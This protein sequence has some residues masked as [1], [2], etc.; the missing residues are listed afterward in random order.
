MNR[1]IRRMS[2]LRTN[3]VKWGDKK[4]RTRTE[5]KPNDEHCKTIPNEVNGWLATM[6]FITA[7][8]LICLRH[9]LLV[10]ITCPEIE[11]SLSHAS[12]QLGDHGCSHRQFRDMDNDAIHPSKCT[13]S[14][15]KHL[16]I[17]ISSAIFVESV[18]LEFDMYM[19]FIIPF[20]IIEWA[21]ECESM[22]T[23]VIACL[24]MFKY[25]WF[26]FRFH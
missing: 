8:C 14:R 20:E 22:M 21:I 6:N 13:K 7:L 9:V 11:F 2:A 23:N 24:S 19:Q 12:D 1:W 5:D 25:A 18:P 17:F 15:V 4:K 10:W 3:N 26:H 16:K